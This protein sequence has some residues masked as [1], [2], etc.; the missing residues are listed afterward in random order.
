MKRLAPAAAV[1]FFIFLHSSCVGVNMDITL[2]RDGTGIITL[3]Y[4]VSQTLDSLGRLDGNERWNTIPVGRADFERTIDRLPEMRLLSFSTKEQGGN[5]ATNA[6]LEF[7]NPRALM[8]FLDA[9]GLHSSLQGDAAGGRILLTL[10][11]GTG[12]KN[13]GLDKLIAD[14]SELYSVRI[15]MT[16]PAEGRLNVTNNKGMG[17]PA[18]PGSE[19]K[20]AGRQV[21]FTVPLYEVLSSTEGINVEFSW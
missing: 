16:F 20:P 3:E 14:I 7:A 17:I 4:L 15:A 6:K 8:A 11:E 9:G 2:N 12:I 13:P 18:I 21:S 19:I 1:V 10:S 5:L